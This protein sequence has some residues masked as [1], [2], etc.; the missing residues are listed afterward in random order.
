VAVDGRTEC[1]LCR[2]RDADAELH[3]VEVWR[4]ELW[5]L[6]ASLAAEVPCFCYLEPLRHVPHIT[7]LDG[8]EAATFGV[9]L[10][11]V[12]SALRHVTGA[13]LV[14]VYV[15]GGGIPHLHVHLAPHTEGDALSEQMIRG[16]LV[17]RHLPSGLT[18]FMSETFP[19]LPEAEQRAT[20]AY[21]RELLAGSLGE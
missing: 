6:T 20:A 18:E 13:E 1:I 21:L 2:G 7:D 5:R 10:G 16:P 12:S 17:E 9:V 3:R 14:Y 11:R 19:P 15:F 8:R 4:D